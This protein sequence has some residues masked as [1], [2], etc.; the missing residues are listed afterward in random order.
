MNPNPG[1]LCIEGRPLGWVGS[2]GN[3]SNLGMGATKLVGIFLVQVSQG[4]GWLKNFR[5]ISM[6]A[7][8]TLFGG[9]PQT[10]FIFSFSS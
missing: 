3:L 4:I 6:L 1:F 5:L 8:G 10:N 9:G 7:G 2:I